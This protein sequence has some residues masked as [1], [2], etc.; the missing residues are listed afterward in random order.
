[1]ENHLN[2]DNYDHIFPEARWENVLQHEFSTILCNVQSYAFENCY[3]SLL[4]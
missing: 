2:V 1:M 3:F 4:K